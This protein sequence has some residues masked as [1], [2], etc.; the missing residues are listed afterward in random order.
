[1][2]VDS[3]AAS[4]NMD[5]DLLAEAF[6]DGRY[7]AALVVDLYGQCADY[8]RIVP[9]LEGAGVTLIEDAAEALGSTYRGRPAG[10][11]GAAAALSFNGNKIITT[12]GGGALVTDLEQ[13]AG[14]AR[15]LATQARDPA[16]H[17][18]HS[19]LGFNYRMSNLLAALGRGQLADLE[20]R[21]GVRR[22]HRAAYLDSL[23]G[24]DGVE[25]MP[26]APGCRSI[27]WLTCVTI[28]PAVTGVDR[29]AVRLRL[30]SIDIVPARLEADA[31]PAVLRG[32]SGGRRVGLRP[33]LRAGSLPPQRF[34]PLCGR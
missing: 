32:V 25:L 22:G 7:A 15:F 20:R 16:P 1:V 24:I 21:I 30:E 34:Q 33:A 26:E 2:F 14:H 18:Q 5:P 17:Y 3:E 19:E 29:E 31:P 10:S 13:W 9:A 6:A 8:D 28:D 11:F 27:F 12:S 4:W 23:G